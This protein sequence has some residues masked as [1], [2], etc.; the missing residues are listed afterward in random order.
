MLKA[1]Q[2][3]TIF[4]SNVHTLLTVTFLLVTCSY[5]IQNLLL[6]V[7]QQQNNKTKFFC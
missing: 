4:C 5:K 7:H 1:P 3:G 2:P 6:F